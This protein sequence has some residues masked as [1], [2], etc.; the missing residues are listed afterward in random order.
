LDAKAVIKD[1]SCWMPQSI[2]T[3]AGGIRRTAD[4][5]NQRFEV[6]FPEKRPFFQEN[7]TYFSTPIT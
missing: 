6:L 4:H 3:S 5:V 7:S 1:S 2:P